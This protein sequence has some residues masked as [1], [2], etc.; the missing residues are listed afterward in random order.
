[1]MLGART[2]AWAKSGGGLPTARDYVQDG[3]VAMWDGIENAGWGVHDSSVMV[4]QD[5]VRSVGAGIPITS[6][7]GFAENG[8]SVTVDSGVQFGGTTQT[9]FY[10][11]DFPVDTSSFECVFTADEYSQNVNNLGGIFGIE[12]GNFRRFAYGMPWGVKYF[13]WPF[14]IGFS[15]YAFDASSI[16]NT[17]GRHYVAWSQNDESKDRMYIDSELIKSVDTKASSISFAHG[18]KFN[19]CYN[20]LGGIGGVYHCLR[21][22][23]RALTAAEIAANYA[24]DK[25]RF[26]LS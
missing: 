21:I 24:V 3:L 12:I 6:T 19:R 23:N 15:L 22:Y 11:Q 1:M 20:G 4:W 9:S 16:F 26:N 13:S 5:L 10:L 8:L 7:M 14:G 2:A 25:A 18:M 17:P